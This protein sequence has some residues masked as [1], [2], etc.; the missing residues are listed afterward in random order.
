TPNTSWL[1]VMGRLKP[2]ASLAQV[3]SNL[4]MVF[5]QALAGA[6]GAKLST[7]DRQSLQNP[8]KNIDVSSGSN[9]FSRL[10]HEFSRPLLLLM[11]VVGLVL[12]IACVNVANLLL[13][14]AS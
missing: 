12:L 1:Q 2:G 9:G 3:R 4:N 6:Y 7:D 10:R 5:R 8:S 14:R 11:V 13:A